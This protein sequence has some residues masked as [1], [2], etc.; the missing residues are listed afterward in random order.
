MKKDV[1]DKIMEKNIPGYLRIV[2]LWAVTQLNYRQPLGDKA[3]DNLTEITAPQVTDAIAY[4][5]GFC[6]GTPSE[7]AMKRLVPELHEK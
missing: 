1:V 6:Q 3:W 5:T 7:K 4:I 2:R